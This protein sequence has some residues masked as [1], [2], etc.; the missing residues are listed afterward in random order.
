MAEKCDQRVTLISGEQRVTRPM[1]EGENQRSDPPAVVDNAEPEANRNDPE[2][3]S[4]RVPPA[5]PTPHSNPA[6][7]R[8]VLLLLHIPVERASM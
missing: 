4:Q 8:Q 1:T 2:Q 7:E 3:D 6:L 5:A